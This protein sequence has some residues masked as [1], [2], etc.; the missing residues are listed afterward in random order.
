MVAAFVLYLVLVTLCNCQTTP[1][2][3]G[4]FTEQLRS[5]WLTATGNQHPV[6][7]DAAVPPPPPPLFQI[8]GMHKYINATSTTQSAMDHYAWPKVE[9]KHIIEDIAVFLLG[10]LKD[11]VQ[12][13]ESSP[14]KV[15]HCI[16]QH[17]RTS[18]LHPLP[19][20]THP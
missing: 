14:D 17:L 12:F 7:E 9:S 16:S 13:G 8:S 15:R 10:T 19:H 1:S 18:S 3:A 6:V 2:K 20:S 11:T 5:K 4:G